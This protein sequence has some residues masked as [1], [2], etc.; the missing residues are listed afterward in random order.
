MKV[1]VLSQDIS[2]LNIVDYILYK[3]YRV[4]K[5][6]SLDNLESGI[7]DFDLIIF[8]YNYWLNNIN[9]TPKADSLKSIPLIILTE[10]KSSDELKIIKQEYHAKIILKEPLVKKDLKE[11]IKELTKKKKSKKHKEEYQ[12]KFENVESSSDKFSESISNGI[13][14]NSEIIFFRV[15]DFD[16]RKIEFLSDNFYKLTGRQDRPAS[17]SDVI[18]PDDLYRLAD[19][20]ISSSAPDYSLTYRVLTEHNSE[21]IVKETGKGNFDGRD[22]LTSVEG[23]ICDITSSYIKENL[24]SFLSN[25]FSHQSDN[26]DSLLSKIVNDF[27]VLSFFR[28]QIQL[29]LAFQNKHY[30]AEGFI[31][32]DY[33]ISSPIIWGNKNIGEVILFA[34]EHNNN[35][36]DDT[37]KA[38][39][40]L[41]KNI[42]TLY[43]SESKRNITAKTQFDALKNDFDSLSK[44]YNQ[45][46]SALADKS[47]S[48]DNLNEIFNS[49]VKDYKLVNS[50][51]NRSIIIFEV[52]NNGK[53]LTANENYYRAIQG[54]REDLAGRHFDH[55]FENINWEGLQFEFFNNSNQEINLKQKTRDGKAHYFSMHISREEHNG[56][57]KFVFYG[58]DNTEAKSLQIE[59]AKQVT[60]Y[61]NTVSDFVVL[62]EK[63][64]FILNENIILKD[65]LEKAKE[66]QQVIQ[67]EETVLHEEEVLEEQNEV[68]QNN[69]NTTAIETTQTT[70]EKA[71]DNENIFKNLRGIDFTKG[72]ISAHNNVDT[73][74][75][76]LVNF[77]NDYS[78]F[79]DDIKEH[80]LTNE[81]EDIL[82]KLK[83]LSEEAGYIGA[84]DLDDSARLFHDKLND[85]KVTNFDFEL[86]VLNVHLNF[87]LDSIKKYKTE[88]SLEHK[89]TSK[90]YLEAEPEENINDVFEPK[91]VSVSEQESD[92]ETVSDS[93]IDL[94][95]IDIK[96]LIS[97]EVQSEEN[98]SLIKE[99]LF[100][101]K[102]HNGDISKI[103]KIQELETSIES[104][105]ND[106]AIRALN[107]LLKF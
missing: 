70:E 69:E 4:V 104:G 15:N 1:L 83:I 7:E 84:E 40:E 55:M 96:D 62:K 82:S 61:N 52:N 2:L 79:I 21:V 31:A 14:E 76:I 100:Q 25:V 46:R 72:L 26:I 50:K 42:I 89:E 12:T 98:T 88:Y 85:G 10:D 80:Q 60:S 35:L 44:Q 3:D 41:L 20:K 27:S 71:L 48:F 16:Q 32:T 37:A 63:Y 34:N 13:I 51:L 53:F 17:L 22:Y 94:L 86:S 99:K 58:K 103:E 106:T 43:Y 105:D 28:N 47:K 5:S 92:K 59:L 19:L 23:T 54:Q 75:E 39:V 11:A 95:L 18:H 56:V 29:S 102:F 73:Y 101:L 77:L 8:D 24:I 97:S 87:T 90:D 81:T 67:H 66:V 36:L 33:S 64:E 107:E 78:T 57:Y 30:F 45:T 49:A 38:F 91:Q 65:E 93:R 9:L 6:T 68:N 74:N